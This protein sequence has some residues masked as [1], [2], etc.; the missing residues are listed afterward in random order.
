MANSGKLSSIICEQR[1]RFR[2]CVRRSVEAAHLYKKSVVLACIE[3]MITAD[4]RSAAPSQV[5]EQL[6][7]DGQDGKLMTV[8]ERF[9]TNSPDA[10]NFTITIWCSENAYIDQDTSVG[11]APSV[12]VQ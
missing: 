6:M 5:K 2:Q 12:G 11:P 9:A 4:E 8:L 3:L 10:T 7:Q 1:P